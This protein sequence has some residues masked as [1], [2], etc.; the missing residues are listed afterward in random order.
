MAVDDSA[1]PSAATRLMRQGSPASQPAANST[2]AQPSTC[3]LPV[4]KMGRRMAQAAGFAVPAHQKSMST[5]PN[6]GKVQDVLHI[7]HQPQAPRANGNAA[8]R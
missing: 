1:S 3:A 2:A 4:P 8:A 7:A 5:T 6:S